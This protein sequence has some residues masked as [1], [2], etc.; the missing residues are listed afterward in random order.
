[1][2]AGA[3]DT[4]AL[5]AAVA[6]TTLV[7]AL[8][9]VAVFAPPLLA[10][11]AQADLGVSASAVGVIIT[12]TYI[13][14]SLSA[15]R[16]GAL[17]ARHGP[18]RVSQHSL[19]WSAGGIALFALAS[20][21]VCVMGAFML[22]MGYGPV[23]PASSTIL[24]TRAP[25]RLRNVIMSIRQTGVPLGGAIAGAL[26]PMLIVAYGWRVAALGVGALCAMT[27]LA[28]QPRREL[29]DAGRN[30]SPQSAR[31]SHLA[32]LRLVFAAPA[33]RDIAL[34]SFAYA[35][36]Q[37]C[38]TSYLVVFLTER[39]GLSLV[40]AG[41]VFSAAMIAGIAGR[42]VWG[43]AADVMGNARVV[44]GALGVVMAACA[45][46][47]T[48]VS[49]QWPYA[50]VVALAVVFGASAIG[51]NGVFVAEVARIAPAG[52]IAQAT[53]ATLG[54]TYFGVVVGPFVFWAI[55]TG[56]ASY[57]IAFAAIGVGALVAGLACFRIP[58]RP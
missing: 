39:C 25:D 54:M 22:G 9:S 53:G 36:V 46:T 13:A 7:Q 28:V 1:M 15:P 20:P 10:P 51:W 55:V 11:A 29:Y 24:S 16:G 50:G 49:A 8:V 42:V 57:A 3:A 40:T 38:F 41:A 33:L 26:V 52:D 21:V 17:V 37:V 43:V 35:A 31:V 27:A 4:R 2:S 14:A 45:F 23:T 6:V 47:M 34:I 30:R 58:G 19:L 56:T 44:L 18:L 5:V 12:L 32:L 48:Q